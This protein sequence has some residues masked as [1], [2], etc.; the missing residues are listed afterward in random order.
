M[1]NGPALPVSISL[2]WPPTL[3]ALWAP[4]GVTSLFP[5][6]REVKREARKAWQAWQGNQ[7]SWRSLARSLVGAGGTWRRAGPQIRIPIKTERYPTRNDFDPILLFLEIFWLPSEI[8]RR[9]VAMRGGGAA[10]SHAALH[11]R[12]G[13]A[14]CG[15]KWTGQLEFSHEGG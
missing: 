6:K 15:P 14:P 9:L 2:R 11:S 5:A 10:R 13:V 4:T 3:A 1:K 12:P 7:T 8:K